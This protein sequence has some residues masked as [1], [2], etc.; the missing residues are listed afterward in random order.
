MAS[1]THQRGSTLIEVLVSIML[2]TFTLAGMAGLLGVATRAQ[3][4]VET[5]SNINSA[6][7]DLANR[8]RANLNTTDPA[9]RSTWA[10]HYTGLT[11]ASQ[12]WSDQQGTS[13]TPNVNCLTSTCSQDELADFDVSEVRARLARTMAQPALQLS[14]DASSGIQATFMWFDKDYTTVTG[15]G[16]TLNTSPTCSTTAATTTNDWLQGQT[17]CPAAAGVSSTP[18]VRCLNLMFLP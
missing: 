10:A 6:L 13:T 7:N 4:G 5:R 15:T 18:G 17:C 2:M 16:V 11:V 14:G 1:N 8:I 3:L 9:H 12:S